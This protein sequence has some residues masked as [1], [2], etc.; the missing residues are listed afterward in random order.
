MCL[1]VIY[2]C[3]EADPLTQPQQESSSAPSAASLSSS[4]PTP[5]LALIPSTLHA[6]LDQRQ[7]QERHQLLAL[8]LLWSRRGWLLQAGD[9]PSSKAAQRDDSAEAGPF[10]LTVSAI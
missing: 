2:S 10:I 8:D 1:L 4:A 7:V 3:I 5:T 9:Y 6:A